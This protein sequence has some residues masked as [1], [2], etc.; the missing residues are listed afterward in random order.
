MTRYDRQRG[1]ALVTTVVLV[2]VLMGMAAIV[3]D[4]G[5]WYHAD[6]KLQATMDAAALAG[7]Q[8]LPDNPAE[9]DALAA[10]YA[11]KNGGGLS[12]VAFS[13]SSLTND[14][15]E[16]VGERPAPGFF[17]KMFGIESVQVHARAKA[18]TGV[19]S[20]ARW[21]APVTVSE[22]HPMLP[23]AWETSTCYGDE[24]ELDLI[25]LHGPGSGDAAGSFGLLDLRPGGNGSAGNS[26]V[27]SWMSEGFDE[28]M[29]RGIY[30]AVPS[31]MFNSTQFRSALS[32]RIGTE[33]LFPIYRPPITASGSNARFDI[34]GWVGF[35]VL[36]F[37]GGGSSGKVH[38]WFTQVIWEGIQ[39]ESGSAENFGAY[40]VTLLE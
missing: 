33:V 22:E 3:L 37:T 1:Q 16:V 39:A 34:I 10:E 21:V 31:T 29:P 12:E 13:S 14:T 2:A 32:G 4:V 8:A 26:E 36:G 30:E 9:A 20:S 25:N 15:I 19:I 27:A 18:R 24:A 40:A 6:R 23:C 11:E 28:S 7:A 5:S 35:H 38:G 17:A